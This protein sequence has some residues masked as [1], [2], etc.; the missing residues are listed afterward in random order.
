MARMISPS[1]SS[2]CSSVHESREAFGLHLQRA[3]RD[4]A[5]VGGL[6]GREGHSGLGRDA[7][8]GRC[9]GHVGALGDDPAAV[10]NERRSWDGG[11]SMWAPNAEDDPLPN[12]DRAARTVR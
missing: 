8:G 11:L 7:D 6:T 1:R 9:G 12:L 3:G 2:V 4:A 5:G 10:A